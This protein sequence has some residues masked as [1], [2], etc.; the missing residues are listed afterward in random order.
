MNESLTVS[1]SPHVRADENTRSIMLDMLIALSF[2]LAVAVYFFGWRALTLAAFSVT[3]CIVFEFTYRKLLKKPHSLGDFSAPVT[4]LLLCFIM[5]VTV[6]YWM[7]AAGAFFAIVVVKQ[8]Y[9]GL[10]KNFLNP[11]LAARA[12][13]A[14][15]TALS[16]T[17]KP[18]IDPRGDMI[19]IWGA[20][21]ADAVSQATPLSYIKDVEQLRITGLPLE[22]DF[23]W[24]NLLLGQIPGA[25]GETSAALLLMGGLYLMVRRVITPRIPAAFLGTVALFT[26]LFPRGGVDGF[27]YMLYNLLSGGL[28]LGAVFMAT[29]YATSPVTPRG[30]WVFGAGCGLLTV[31]FRYFSDAPEG[32]CYAILLMNTVVWGLDR[33]GVPRRFGRRWQRREG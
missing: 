10:G 16:V 13:L 18:L 9:G 31:F 2:P 27:D 1:S 15:F 8:L 33:I 19:P 28:I 17:I 20:F 26:F 4:G 3:C 14:G 25:I 11:A 32:V 7:V 23:T 29:D 21:D 24:A 12:F 5:P 22:S 6:P 30:Q